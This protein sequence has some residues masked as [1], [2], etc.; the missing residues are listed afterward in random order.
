MALAIGRES[1]IL[2]E[3]AEKPFDYKYYFS[4]FKKNFYVILTFFI[5]TVT[6]ASIYVAKMPDQYQAVA[7]LIL[8]RPSLDFV[9]EQG[10]SQVEVESW[11][12]D[13]YKTQI[14]IM[15]SNAVLQG[16]VKE[17][18]LLDV[19]E[20][21]N[22]EF[23]VNKLRFMLRVDRIRGSRLFNIRIIAAEPKLASDLANGVARAF[24]Q[25]NFE[26]SLYYAKEVL[27]WLPQEGRA[28]DT[29]TVKDPFGGVRQMTRTEVIENL[30][31]LQTD[32]TL[33]ELREK[34]NQQ[35]AE[36][37]TL[38]RQYR[39]K[40][41]IVVKA[42][43]NLKFLEESIRAEKNRIIENLK[44]Q[45]EGRMQ[46]SQGRVIEEA[47][48]PK[49][50]IGP[51]RSRIVLIA[52]LAE[53]LL[54]LILIFLIDY[55]DDTIHS[56]E[57][58][59]RKGILLPFLGPLPLLRGKRLA[60]DQIPLI[61]ESDEKSELAEAFRYLRV[62]INF[63]APAEALKTLLVTSCLPNEGKS[64]VAQNIAV[65]LAMDGNKTLLIDADLRR[66]VAHRKFRLD[67]TTGLSNYL[68]SNL[69]FDSVVKESFVEN[70]FIVVSG[71]VS[72]N[73]AEILGSDRMKNFLAEA[74]RRFDRVIIDCP[75]LTGIGDGLVV[76]SLIGHV[77]IVISSGRTPADLI[78]HTQRQLEKTGTK[79]IGTILNRVDMEKER[80]GGYTKHYYQTYHRYY[81]K[82]DDKQ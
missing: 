18:R 26:Y 75:P 30:P 62:A 39:E 5:I 81:R 63:S 48:I 54:S 44:L 74:R 64:F 23:A 69:D 70:F 61:T 55:F 10:L 56:L 24:I 80:Y 45:A 50:P 52:G 59:E 31:A 7:Q 71:P 41:P 47:K 38:L 51:N 3:E 2:L 79:V 34:K 42:R 68:T 49:A 76:G 15:Q 4:L 36:L 82:K 32:A 17:K 13:Y 72:P 57:D 12:E 66:P 21:D 27:N 28:M 78:H 58:L 46:V 29:I 53:L 1:G 43:A 9:H 73:P 22:E 25:K 35:E 14:E 6:I 37:T 60:D 40:H 77:I 11:T 67:N 16:V 65:S 33:R 20:T 19:F 8:E